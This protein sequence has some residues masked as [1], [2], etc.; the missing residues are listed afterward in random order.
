MKLFSVI[1]AAEVLGC[2]KR[3]VYDLIQKKKLRAYQ[4]EYH[5]KIVIDEG[6]LGMFVEHLIE[7]EAHARGG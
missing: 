4:L 2:G 1:E 7:Y 3:K 5:G 6:D